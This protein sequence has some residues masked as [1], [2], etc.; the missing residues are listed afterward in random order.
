M[1]AAPQR[2]AG[3]P[4]NP[5]GARPCCARPVAVTQCGV[6]ESRAS[7]CTW[8]ADGATEA[9]P[10]P[11]RTETITGDHVL[12]I[13]PLLSH[14]MPAVG[15][16]V[17][18]YGVAVVQQAETEAAQATVRLGQRLLDR[19]LRRAPDRAPIEAAVEDLAAAEGDPDA[20]AALRFQI[21]R[22]LLADESLAAEWAAML[23]ERPSVRADGAGG[24]AVA[25]DVT[26]IVSTGDGATNVMRR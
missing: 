21:R 19:V 18:A 17:G 14:A 8:E 13:E 20:L 3:S 9:E 15:A 22:A 10:G 7:G 12:D 23:P 5:P 24:V 16:A 4:P 26:G 11:R 6:A 1:P 25:G 2:Q